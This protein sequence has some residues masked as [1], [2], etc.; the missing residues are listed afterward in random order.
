MSQ[1]QQQSRA[2]ERRARTAS[3]AKVVRRRARQ[4]AAQLIIERHREEYDRLVDQEVRV[5]WAEVAMFKAVAPIPDGAKTVLLRSG[6]RKPEEAPIHRID[7]ATCRR[8]HTSHDR[9][10]VCPSCGSS[11]EE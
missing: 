2:E 8:C 1:P 9:G 7:T 5:A 6:R 4:R 3:E 11:E 10:H